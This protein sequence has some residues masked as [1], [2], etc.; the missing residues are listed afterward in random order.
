MKKVTR[1][2]AAGM[3]TTSKTIDGLYQTLEQRRMALLNAAYNEHQNL[4]RDILECPLSREILFE[5]I[6]PFVERTIQEKMSH[7]EI[8]N[9]AKKIAEVIFEG[10]PPES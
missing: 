2:S 9:E 8:Q 3:T 10:R 7:E 4:L 6:E 5:A 1:R